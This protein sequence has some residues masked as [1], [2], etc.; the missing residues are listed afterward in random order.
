MKEEK[1]KLYLEEDESDEFII[2]ELTEIHGG[3][4]DDEISMSMSCGLGCFL[5][6]G[7]GLI[8]F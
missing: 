6:A 8:G 1:V 2:D 7:S 3:I 5:G 4:E